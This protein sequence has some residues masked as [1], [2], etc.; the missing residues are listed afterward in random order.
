MYECGMNG[1]AAA[2]AVDTVLRRKS[3]QSSFVYIHILWMPSYLA[4]KLIPRIHAEHRGK[5][6]SRKPH[7]KEW[8]IRLITY[9]FAP[10]LDSWLG[11][12]CTQFHLVCSFCLL[13][14][15]PKQNTT[16][17]NP[18]VVIE[19]FSIQCGKNKLKNKQNRKLCSIKSQQWIDAV[20][21]IFTFLMPFLRQGNC[22]FVHHFSSPHSNLWP[23]Q[24]QCLNMLIYTVFMAVF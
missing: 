4:V 20:I 8:T 17:K 13:T 6:F 10:F 16:K 12:A 21:F 9:I 18:V 22:F 11:G 24:M 5:N 23:I 3:G 1:A 15:N 2:A 19:V 7:A 14:E